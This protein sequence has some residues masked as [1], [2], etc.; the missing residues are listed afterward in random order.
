VQRVDAPDVAEL[1]ITA[2]RALGLSGPLDIDIRRRADNVP[3]VLEINARFGIHIA[4]AP[5]VLDAAL[6]NLGMA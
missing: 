4:Q 2:G 1:A 6:A 3:V 5:E